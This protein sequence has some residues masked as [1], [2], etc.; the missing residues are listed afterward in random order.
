MQWRNAYYK[1]TTQ[2][3]LTNLHSML[4]TIT[5]QLPYWAKKG[6]SSVPWT[7]DSKVNPIHSFDVIPKLTAMERFAR[8]NSKFQSLIWQSGLALHQGMFPILYVSRNY[9][10]SFLSPEISQVF[11]H[12]TPL[13]FENIYTKNSLPLIYLSQTF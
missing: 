7:S 1:I 2:R 9:F 4:N 8:T 12:S 5:K 3:S 10:V 11:I 13:K 6:G